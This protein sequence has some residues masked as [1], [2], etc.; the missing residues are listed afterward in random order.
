MTCER[1]VRTEDFAREGSFHTLRISR[2]LVDGV[3][4]AP[5]G[6]HFTSCT[7]DYAC[8]EAFLARYAGSASS[9]EA[10]A[11]FRGKYLEGDEAAYQQ[12]VGE[13]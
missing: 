5:N 4:E 8:D 10:W 6:A 12:R 9:P 7:P 1:L 2:M 11:E 13:G 3:A